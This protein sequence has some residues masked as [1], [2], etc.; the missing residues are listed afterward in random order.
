MASQACKDGRRGSGPG[1]NMRGEGPGGGGQTDSVG[2]DRQ[3]LTNADNLARGC[4]GP[5]CKGKEDGAINAVGGTGIVL[6]ALDSADVDRVI[7]QNMPSIRYCYQKELQGHPGLSGKVS[8]KFTIA[9]DGT[10]S[11]ATTRT[12][13]SMPAVEACLS[14]RFL[15]MKFPRPKGGGVVIVSYPFVFSEG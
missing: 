14:A 10:V 12:G 6:G 3:S 1:L 5:R 15:T 8:V 11:S 4:E 13:A 9:A 7:K 2:Y